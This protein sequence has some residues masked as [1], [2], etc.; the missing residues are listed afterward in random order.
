MSLQNRQPAQ[1]VR[2]AVVAVVLVAAVALVTVDEASGPT[3][4][5]RAARSPMPC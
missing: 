4:W 3:R 5:T 2:W 1:L